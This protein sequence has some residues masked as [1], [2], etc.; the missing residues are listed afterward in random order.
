[1][2]LDCIKKHSLGK[3]RGGA[4]WQDKFIEFMP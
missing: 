4:S 3:E 1:M 2:Q